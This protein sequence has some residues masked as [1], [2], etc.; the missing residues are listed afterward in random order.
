MGGEEF[1]VLMPYSG[2]NEAYE[3]IKKLKYILKNDE[4]LSIGSEH[5]CYSFSAGISDINDS[6]SFDIEI[7]LKIA[8]KRLYKAKITGRDKIIYN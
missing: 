2:K 3:T 1:L 8:D 7:L 4:C 5:I 6:D